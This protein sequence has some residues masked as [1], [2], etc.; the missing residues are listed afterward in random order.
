MTEVSGTPI[1]SASD[2]TA[3]VRAQAAGADVQL[4]YVRGGQ[5]YE[6]DVTLGTMATS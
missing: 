4:T 5:S 3:Q 1:T 2:L 6:V